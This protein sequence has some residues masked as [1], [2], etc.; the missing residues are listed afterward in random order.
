MED[1][2]FSTKFDKKQGVYYYSLPKNTVLYRGDSSVIGDTMT[3]TNSQTFFGFNAVNVETN[4]GTTFEFKTK[5]PLKLIALDKNQDTPFYDSLN[6]ENQEVLNINYGYTN[7]RGERESVGVKDR[8]ISSHICDSYPG[9]HG[10]A[11]DTMNT[12]AGGIFHSEAMLCNPEDCL[13]FVRRVTTDEKRE[14]LH[15]EYR[16][17]KAASFAVKKRPASRNYYN[18]D[19]SIKPSSFSLSLFGSDDE[20]V[21]EDEDEDEDKERVVVHRRLFGGDKKG[22]TRKHRKQK[23]KQRT[24]R[25]GKMTRRNK[26]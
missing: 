19:D 10:Y 8:M 1:T 13:T 14:Q 21:D 18:E 22:R 2:F 9:Y 20:D 25:T 3:L 5:K 15:E 23:K 24:R 26:K 12:V 11:C 4:Y 16:A 7:P 17:R 6:E